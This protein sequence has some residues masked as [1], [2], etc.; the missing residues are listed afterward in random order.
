[1]HSERKKTF[2]FGNTCSSVRSIGIEDVDI[3]LIRDTPTTSDHNLLE[4]WQQK[5]VPVLHQTMAQCEDV[6]LMTLL[7]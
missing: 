6:V 7:A 1:M 2:K 3:L 5:I 4:V